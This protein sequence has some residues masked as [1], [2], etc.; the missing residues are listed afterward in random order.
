LVISGQ[1]RHDQ[2]GNGSLTDLD[3]GIS[4]VTIELLDG[5]CTPGLTCRTKVTNVGGFFTFDN[6]TPGN[7]I[8]FETDPAGYVSTNDSDG[9]NDNQI[10]INLVA[11][12]SWIGNR[13][14]DKI[15]P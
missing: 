15:G 12:T 7:Y 5:I 9:V 11:G 3:P 14:L 4:G 13:F 10:T 1:V 8:I 2:D 6:L